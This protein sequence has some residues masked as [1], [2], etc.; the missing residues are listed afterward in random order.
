MGGGDLAGGLSPH[1]AFINIPH[2]LLA[3]SPASAAACVEGQAAWC[4]IGQMDCKFSARLPFLSPEK[5]IPSRQSC[6]APVALRIIIS[7]ELSTEKDKERGLI[8][9]SDCGY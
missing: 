9:D 8:L 4:I 1:L 6:L 7:L 5:P 2:H 3:A